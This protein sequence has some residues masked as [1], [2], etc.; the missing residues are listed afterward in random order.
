MHWF[1]LSG[2]E[3]LSEAPR[4]QRD[5]GGRVPQEPDSAEPMY[6]DPGSLLAVV[7]VFGNNRV[8][9]LQVE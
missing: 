3:D 1:V 9:A 6:L 2:C 4:S 5:Q 7:G 8:M